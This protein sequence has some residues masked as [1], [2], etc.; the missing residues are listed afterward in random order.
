MNTLLRRL[1]LIARL[2]VDWDI[3]K[4]ALDEMARDPLVMRRLQNALAADPVLAACASTLRTLWVP[5]ERDIKEL[6]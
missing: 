6:R 2:L 3:F 5:I 1:R 4:H